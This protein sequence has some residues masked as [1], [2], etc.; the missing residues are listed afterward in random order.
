MAVAATTFL[1]HCLLSIFCLLVLVPFLPSILSL[2]LKG[3]VKALELFNIGPLPVNLPTNEDRERE[4]NDI[5]RSPVYVCIDNK[6]EVGVGGWSGISEGLKFWP[7][8]HPT[9]FFSFGNH[10]STVCV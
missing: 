4:N 8:F 5:E 7:H 1:W 9:S 10:K 6:S 2:Y 3:T